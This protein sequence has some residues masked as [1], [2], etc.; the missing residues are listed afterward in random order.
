MPP[1]SPIH[2]ESNFSAYT[3]NSHIPLL[4]PPSELIP[5]IPPLL[6][7]L[8]EELKILRLLVSILTEDEL[9]KQEEELNRRM[10]Q[11]K[12]RK[13]QTSSALAEAKREVDNFRESYEMFQVED[14]SLDKGFKR[15]FAD[16]DPHTV[17]QLYKL[18]KRRPR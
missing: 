10:E 13:A 5:P 11:L 4:S 7:S 6:P 17:E 16:L 2:Q 1:P 15:E 14:K 8:Q 12:E 18:F 9:D 3:F